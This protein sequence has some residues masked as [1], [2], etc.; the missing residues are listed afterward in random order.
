LLSKKNRLPSHLISQVL[1]QGQHFHSSFFTLIIYQAQLV[2]HRSQSKFAF[3]IS[4]KIDK[5]AVI[6][7]RLKRQ[8]GQVIQ[9]NLNRIKKGARVVILVR[10][11][12]T[13]NSWLSIKA[14][15]EK[16]LK[17]SGLIK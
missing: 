5:R 9:L 11:G 2:G 10:K 12:W 7:N 3:I 16:I 8:L 13:P 15:I 1:K 14:E 17:T 6:R 4:T